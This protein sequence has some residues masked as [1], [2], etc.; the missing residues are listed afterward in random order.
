MKEI[1]LPHGMSTIVDDEDYKNLNQ[2]NWHISKS[3]NTSYAI[4]ASFNK[5]KR[6]TERIHRVVMGI[7]DTSKIVDHINGNGLDNRKENLRICNSK[8]NRYNSI[9]SKN[10]S[11]IYKGV[12]K[13]TRTKNIK[14]LAQICLNYKNINLGRFKEEKEAAIAYDKAALKYFGKFANLNFC[15][16][17]LQEKKQIIMPEPIIYIDNDEGP[18]SLEEL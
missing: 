18:E 7:T 3:R 6:S 17:I 1:K 2:Y 11:S 13:D 8:Q 9:K 10:T 12:T 16:T 4:R 5:G 14:W 15:Q